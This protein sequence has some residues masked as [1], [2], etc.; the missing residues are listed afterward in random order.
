M[1]CPGLISPNGI[2]ETDVREAYKAYYVPS[3]MT[4]V[5]VGSFDRDRQTRR[6][7]DFGLKERKE[8]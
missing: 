6:V 3:N 5:V 2:K 8:L 7:A 4:L 1:T